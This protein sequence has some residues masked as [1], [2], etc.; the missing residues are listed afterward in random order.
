MLSEE[1]TFLTT[2]S[3]HFVKVRTSL[4]VL[5]NSNYK[6]VSNSCGDLHIDGQCPA[7]TRSSY[8]HTLHIQKSG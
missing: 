1:H 3:Y 2:T 5:E 6:M 4:L 8:F 7:K